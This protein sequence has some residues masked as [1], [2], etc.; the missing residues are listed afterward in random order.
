M[1]D[2]DKYIPKT[3]P[4]DHQLEAINYIVDNENIAVFD[5]QGVGKTKEVIDAI[6]I[7]LKNKTIDSALIVCPRSLMYNWQDEIEKHSYLSSVVIEGGN[8]DKEYKFLSASNVYIINY[9]G[10]T[11]NLA[12]T[13]LLLGTEKFMMVLDESQ[14]IK[15]PNSLTFKTIEKIKK[16]SSRRVILTGT[17]VANKAIDIWSQF[18]FLDD[19]QTL[20]A[21]FKEFCKKY[22]KPDLDKETLLD[23]KNKI[24][25]K[26]IRRLKN[27]VLQLPEK[28]FETIYVDFSPIQSQIYNKLRKDL[29]IEIKKIDEQ[30][31]MDESKSIL[32]KLLR[33][34]Q[35]ASNPGMIVADYSETPGKF[36]VLD[37]LI[38]KIIASKEKV[39][40]W[41]SFVEN[42]RALKIRYKDYG[43]LSINGEVP[44]SKRSKIVKDFQN[45]PIFKVLIANPAAAK[46]GLTL[47]AANNAIYLDRNFNLVDY[48][49]SQDRIHRISQQKKCK[50]TKLLIKDSVDLFV[51]DRLSKKQ[52]EAK[53]IQGD[54][55]DFQANLYLTKSE[56]INILN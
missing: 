37:K 12:V 34:V 45:N 50:I 47:T 46:E 48:L 53:I 2:L 28:I 49:Q 4:L 6:L 15:N 40:I 9:E 26:S 3:T 38:K 33:L 7:M 43:S 5:E 35:I 17:P 36:I 24:H 55:E 52:A 18:Y 51:E 27:N 54:S 20:G 22:K 30:V 42:V 23:L 44:I 19:G 29:L 13:E 16:Y 25:T 32:K 21:D 11:S 10:V 8:K 56:I 1:N 39:I 31:V 14:R 41:T